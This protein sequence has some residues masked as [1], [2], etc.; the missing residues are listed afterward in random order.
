MNRLNPYCS[1]ANGHIR[2]T[3]HAIFDK[4][5]K[6]KRMTRTQAYRW[7]AKEMGMTRATAH[8]SKFS[9]TQCEQLIR[10]SLKKLEE[11]PKPRWGRTG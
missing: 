1:F 8:I 10:I 6:S 9:L 11:T 5:W 2:A 7:M 3:A 4:L